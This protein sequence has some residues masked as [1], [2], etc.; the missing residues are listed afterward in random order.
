MAT[1]S[2]A[3]SAEVEYPAARGPAVLGHRG[4][5]P[6]APLFVAA[7]GDHVDVGAPGEVPGQVG[8]ERA[9]GTRDDEEISGVTGIHQTTST[10]ADTDPAWK[11]ALRT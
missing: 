8:V 1:P 11:A 10:R 4:H 2:V 7:V 6:P 9:I 5:V 3:R